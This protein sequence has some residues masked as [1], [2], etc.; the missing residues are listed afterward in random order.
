MQGGVEKP[1]H[2]LARK[3]RQDSPPAFEMAGIDRACGS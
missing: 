1:R 2:S 3:A